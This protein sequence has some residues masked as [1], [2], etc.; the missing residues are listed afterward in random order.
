LTRQS[1]IF[2]PLYCC[3]KDSTTQ[4]RSNQIIEQCLYPIIDTQPEPKRA[5]TTGGSSIY[6]NR[7]NKFIASKQINNKSKKSKKSKKRK[8]KL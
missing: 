5:K 8:I 2:T 7:I 6:K 4:E 3:Y 1:D